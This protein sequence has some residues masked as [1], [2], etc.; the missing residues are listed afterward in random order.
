MIILQELRSI[1]IVSIED[2]F[3]YLS[4]IFLL[5]C[6]AMGYEI[7]YLTLPDKRIFK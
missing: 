3:F 4:Q 6:N 1:E 7:N 5:I 2:S